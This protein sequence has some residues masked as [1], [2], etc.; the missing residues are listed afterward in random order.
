MRINYTLF[1]KV[2][3]HILEEPKSLRQECW[4][5]KKLSN[6]HWWSSYDAVIANGTKGPS[7]GTVACVAGW[8]MLLS[9]GPEYDGGGGISAVAMRELIQGEGRLATQARDALYN[10]IF[11]Y[12]PEDASLKPGTVKYAKAVVKRIDDFLEVWGN[13]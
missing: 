11:M 6:K 10:Y 7:C 9:H 4:I 1:D 5:E 8:T 3:A 12:F 2:K 13:K